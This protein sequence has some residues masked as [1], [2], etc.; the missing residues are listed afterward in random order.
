M[1]SA[2]IKALILDWAGT[3]VD[4]GSLAP[5]AALQRTFEAGGVPI[6]AAE[7]RAQMGV[8]KK[9]QIRF[10]CQGERVHAAWTE[11]H[12]QPPAEQDVERLFSEFL[13]QQVEILAEY[14][15]P[16]PGVCETIESW[17]SAGLR[18]GS[19]TGY[20]RALLDVV[21]P[22]AARL[23]Y[24]PHASVTPDEAGAGRPKPFMC[25][26]NAMLLEVFP[27]WQCVKIGDTPVDIAE[28]INA[29]MWT[30]GITA[31]GNEIGLLPVRVGSLA[32]RRADSSRTTRRTASDGRG[33]EL[34]GGITGR[35]PRVL[36]DI[37]RRIAAGEKP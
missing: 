17:K 3:T 22:V 20:T 37:E 26:R 21:I 4:F 28:G 35:V 32:G 9:D 16:I 2:C 5:V 1:T 33:R 23:G 6:T 34:Y 7:A 27:L 8:L 31:T 18:I 10:I 29:G 14:S 25:Y 36:A 24:S 30:I 13:P 12:G 11:R 19:S 15:A